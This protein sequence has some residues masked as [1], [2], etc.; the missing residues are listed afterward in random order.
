LKRKIV[1]SQDDFEKCD[2]LVSSLSVIVRQELSKCY[3]SFCGLFLE[4]QCH[5]FYFCLKNIQSFLCPALYVS[6]ELF[7]SCYFISH[8]KQNI[9][10]DVNFTVKTFKIVVIKSFIDYNTYF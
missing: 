3:G 7:H 9:F 5:L 4:N 10:R 1:L 2:N 8:C 6:I